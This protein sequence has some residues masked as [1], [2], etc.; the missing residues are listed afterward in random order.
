[1]TDLEIM[2][3]A[4]MYIDKMANGINP[5]TNEYVSPNDTINN[6]RVSRCLFYVSDVLRQVIENDGK[7]SKERKRSNQDFYITDEQKNLLSVIK[8]YCTV[9][10]IANSINE[11]TKENNTKTMPAVWINDW[12]MSIDMLQTSEGSKRPTEKG[13][14]LGITTEPRYSVQHGNYIVNLFSESAQQFIFDNIDAII[15]YHFQ[16][17]GQNQ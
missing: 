13:N 1:M 15:A 17:R 8:E 4:K 9:S 7:V 6:V 16:Q 10:E 2:Q 12:L 5:I 14:Q 3:R 11:I